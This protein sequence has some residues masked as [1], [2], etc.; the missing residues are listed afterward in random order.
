VYITRRIGYYVSHDTITTH[1]QIGGPAVTTEW[2]VQIRLY[3]DKGW[4]ESRVHTRFDN[5]TRPYTR[6]EAAKAVERWNRSFSNKPDETG[7]PYCR[8]VTREV[9]DWEPV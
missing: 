6:E 3:T 1:G 8:L 5:L 9:P 2:G 4:E 7:L